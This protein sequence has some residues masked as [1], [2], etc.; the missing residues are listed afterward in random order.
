MF[1][2]DVSC[3]IRGIY[4]SSLKLRSVQTKKAALNALCEKKTAHSQSW[5]ASGDASAPLQN[6]QTTWNQWEMCLPWSFPLKPW[7]HS[8]RLSQ[9]SGKC[10]DLWSTASNYPVPSQKPHISMLL[11]MQL[12]LRAVFYFTAEKNDSDS[13]W[14]MMQERPMGYMLPRG[15]TVA[16]K[17]QS[18][19]IFTPIMPESP[20]HSSKS[21]FS[22]YK[23]SGQDHIRSCVNHHCL[24][25][26]FRL[27]R[28]IFDS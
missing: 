3:S 27:N 24:Q 15:S 13:G 12:F 16:R 6:S 23:G 20:T 25:V 10:S 18:C 8:H 17:A 14:R 9:P 5:L 22:T 2:V 19:L 21:L 11:S 7:V 28:Q 1:P 26:S 4:F